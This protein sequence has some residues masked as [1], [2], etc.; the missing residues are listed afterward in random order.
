METTEDGDYD[1]YYDDYI[2]I[3]TFKMK[4]QYTEERRIVQQVQ[5]FRKILMEFLKHPVKTVKE[6]IKRELMNDIETFHKE[7]PE[8]QVENDKLYV[9]CF[10]TNSHIF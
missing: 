3:N 10:N 4:L 2:D 8:N 6:E 7:F 9:R 1:S 5:I